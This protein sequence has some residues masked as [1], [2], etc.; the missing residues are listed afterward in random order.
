MII[1]RHR[2]GP[3]A[4]QTQ[5]IETKSGR[6]V[7]GRD[8]NVCDV[9][10]PADA[11]IVA[12]RHFALVRRPSGEWVFDLFGDPFVAISGGPAEMGEAVHSGAVIELGH[13][14]GPSFEILLVK[15]GLSDGLPVTQPQEK[16]IGSHL[17]AAR[18]R[19]LA[20]VGV[21]IAVLA[22]GGAAG[23]YYYNRS[24]AQRLNNAIAALTEAQAEVAAQSI[25]QPV[26]DK[27]VHAAYLVVLKYADGREFAEGT[28]VP[29]AGDMLATNAHIVEAREQLGQG[30]RMLV[31]APGANGQEFEVIQSRKHPAYDAF[32]AFLQQDPF[33]V[34]T[35]NA[36]LTASISYDV[37]ILQIAAGTAL[38]PIMEIASADELASLKAGTPLALAGYPS[39]GV[40]G[41]EVLP[42]AAT[43][44]L[45]LG[46]VT[47]ATDM[48][49]LP[50]DV[51]ERRLIHHNLPTTGGSSGSP[52]VNSNGKLVALNNS[53]NMI[54]VP[55][56]VYPTGRIPSGVLINYAQRADLILDL[57]SGQADKTLDAERAYWEKQ[58]ANFKRG[59]DVLV[60]YIISKNTPQ[61]GATPTQISQDKLTLTKA[62][63]VTVQ[64]GVQRQKLLT[65]I[66]AAA[67]KTYL[68]IGYAE[69]ETS[70]RL[71]VLN[72]NNIVAQNNQTETWYPSV[73]YTSPADGDLDIWV[74]GP[75][76][77][78]NF[79]FLSYR[80]DAPSS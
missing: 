55:T 65:T 31:R 28:A 27:L 2:T 40:A 38:S 75:N 12:R 72:G 77:D 59:F 73:S 57:L 5:Q 22:I 3:L 60:P 45:S 13:R 41:S 23:L 11:T 36:Y 19:R 1:I 29:I 44:N 26:R 17:A 80:W 54:N 48:F 50:A 9:V 47:A 56:N 53:G 70:I 78:V 43:P 71:Y 21:A 33:V 51:S 62:D 74:V 20:S 25:S 15:E 67:G 61:P 58:T 68:F 7:F 30:D 18:A 46:I 64:K 42:L 34:T 35:T 39:E 6:I 69:N 4:G 79:T 16:V 8:P 24:Q 10:Y 66:N 32:N 37:G 76:E 63:A 14:G 52:M 49:Q